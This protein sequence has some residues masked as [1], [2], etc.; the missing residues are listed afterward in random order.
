MKSIMPKESEQSEAMAE[1][2]R[3]MDVVEKAELAAYARHRKISLEAAMTELAAQYLRN[4]E[5]TAADDVDAALALIDRAISQLYD[6]VN[7][8]TEERQLCEIRRRAG[9]IESLIRSLE[10]GPIP[11]GF[12]SL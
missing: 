5:E 1:A 2:F 4:A 11:R 6:A 10:D 8:P 3:I 12:K 9:K 7:H